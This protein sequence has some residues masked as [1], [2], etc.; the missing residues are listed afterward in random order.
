M[1]ESLI[2][3]REGFA[4]SET[5]SKLIYLKVYW[6]LFSRFIKWWDNNIFAYVVVTTL[7][8]EVVLSLIF[9]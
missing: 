2:T 3:N 8:T 6:L 5:L 9:K 7:N 1:L 4:S